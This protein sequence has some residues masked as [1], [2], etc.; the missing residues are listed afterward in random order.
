MWGVRYSWHWRPQALLHLRLAMAPRLTSGSTGQLWRA[1][2][3]SL[4]SVDADGLMDLKSTALISKSNVS[5]FEISLLDNWYNKYWKHLYISS[6]FVSKLVHF[7]RM[8]MSFK[9]SNFYSINYKMLPVKSGFYWFKIFSNFPLSGNGVNF[10]LYTS[11]LFDMTMSMNKP[12][13]YWITQKTTKKAKKTTEKRRQTNTMEQPQGNPR[14]QWL[15]GSCGEHI[16]YYGWFSL[17]LNNGDIEKANKHNGS[18][19]IADFL[20]L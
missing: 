3:H 20:S 13:K 12:I 1:R 17:S 14:T 7:E 9:A 4:K 19:I 6:V 2:N 5:W 18:F 15:T 10:F 16:I 8:A 11:D